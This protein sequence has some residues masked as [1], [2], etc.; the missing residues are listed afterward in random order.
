MTASI[1]ALVYVAIGVIAVIALRRAAVSA[2][3]S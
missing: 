1:I 3:R 2:A